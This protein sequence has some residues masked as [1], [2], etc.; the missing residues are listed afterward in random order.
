MKRLRVRSTRDVV[1]CPRN[2]ESVQDSVSTLVK[3]SSFLLVDRYYVLPLVLLVVHYSTR[4]CPRK[5]D[6]W[7]ERRDFEIHVQAP[8]DHAC[9]LP[10]CEDTGM[11]FRNSFFLKKPTRQENCTMTRWYLNATTSHLKLMRPGIILILL[12]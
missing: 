10:F 11:H 12:L 8:L 9:L 2:E 5:S 7:R 4:L 1:E 3:F 6:G